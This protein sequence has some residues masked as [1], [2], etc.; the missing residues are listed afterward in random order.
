MLSLVSK[1]AEELFGVTDE[2]ARTKTTFALFPEKQP[3]A[4][5][6]RLWQVAFV[7]GVAGAPSKRGKLRIV[8]DHWDIDYLY[9]VRSSTGLFSLIALLVLVPSAVWHSRIRESR[10]RRSTPRD[11]RSAPPPGRLAPA[12]GGA[13]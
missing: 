7:A 10:V 1:E 6:S 5:L 12:Q 9:E 3:E 2:G 11:G 13:A 8:F 4:S